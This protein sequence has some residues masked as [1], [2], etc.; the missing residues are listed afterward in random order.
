MLTFTDCNTI[1]TVET[2][3]FIIGITLSVLLM[4]ISQNITI[5]FTANKIITTSTE[6]KATASLKVFNNMVAYSY[7]RPY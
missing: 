1:N 3:F 7:R 5:M 2:N 6:P 4:L